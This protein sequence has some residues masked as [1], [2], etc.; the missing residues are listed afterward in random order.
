MM[1]AQSAT[2][3]KFLKCPKNLKLSLMIPD[4]QRKSKSS[5]I[6]SLNLKNPESKR[7]KP[8][9]MATKASK[10]RSKT[11][12]ERLILPEHVLSSSTLTKTNFKEKSRTLSLKLTTKEGKS[13]TLTNQM[14][15]KVEKT[16]K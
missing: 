10:S 7:N 12:K 3:P 16:L 8:I 13:I 2:I 15:G 11:K 14:I 9:K 1:K 5:K 4:T 6:G